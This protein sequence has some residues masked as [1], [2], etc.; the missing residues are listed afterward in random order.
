[1]TTTTKYGDEFHCTIGGN[2][3]NLKE[4]RGEFNMRYLLCNLNWSRVQFLLH[5]P[6][7][8]KI[9]TLIVDLLGLIG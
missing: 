8:M 1:M 4:K 3:W 6:I 7:P 9:A 2:R 5:C